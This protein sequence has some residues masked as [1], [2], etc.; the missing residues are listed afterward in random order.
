[1]LELINNH[2][3]LIIGGIIDILILKYVYTKFY[4]KLKG[5]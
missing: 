2:G 1:M 5:D 4:H 3:L